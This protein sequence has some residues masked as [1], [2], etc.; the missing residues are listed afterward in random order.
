[1][2]SV[3]VERPLKGFFVYA[4]YHGQN[5]PH[6]EIYEGKVF[7]QKIGTCYLHYIPE[8]DAVAKFTCSLDRPVD[9]SQELFLLMQGDEICLHSF[10][11]TI[12]APEPMPYEKLLKNYEPVPEDRLVDTWSDT[13]VLTDGLGRSIPDSNEVG[14]RRKN[15]YIGIFYWTWHTMGVTIQVP[16]S[17]K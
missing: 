8:R 14:L 7:G 2:K 12:E 4:S 17:E 16:K 11:F 1:L 6:I 15:K 5:D 10:G 3:Q 9:G 13:W